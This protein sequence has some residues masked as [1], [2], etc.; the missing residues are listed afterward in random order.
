MSVFRFCVDRWLVWLRHPCTNTISSCYVDYLSQITASRQTRIICI[1]FVQCWTNVED[2]G[3]TLYKCYADV[4]CLLRCYLFSLM[5]IC[6]S[7]DNSLNLVWHLVNWCWVSVVC[8]VPTLC[9]LWANV[10]WFLCCLITRKMH[11]NNHSQRFWQCNHWPYIDYSS[12]WTCVFEL[13]T[14]DVNTLLDKLSD[15]KDFL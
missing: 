5:I 10:S 9:R 11:W 13:D 2:V 7:G 8:D 15:N 3:P 6:E 12:H 4:L 1:T 14:W